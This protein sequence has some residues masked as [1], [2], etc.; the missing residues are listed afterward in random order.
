MS[1][2][3]TRENITF[4]SIASPGPQI[5]TIDSDSN[6]PTMAYG[7]AR[8]L[9]NIPPSLKG[10][11]LPPNSFNILATNVVA[12]PTAERDDENY[13]LE[14]PKL[15]EPSPISKHP[16]K[17]SIIEGWETPHTTM[18]DK[19]STPMMNPEEFIFYPQVLLHHRHLE[20]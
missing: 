11:N 8:Q 13:S 14:L 2:N 3:N 20:S 6:E 16:M 7:F 17:L 19:H 4:S 10:L 12:N 5:V 1:G 18:D 15:S 9:P